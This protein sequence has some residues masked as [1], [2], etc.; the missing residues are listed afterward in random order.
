MYYRIEHHI[1][2]TLLNYS[3]ASKFLTKKL[4]EVYDLSGCKYFVI[5]NIRFN[6]AM[7]RSDLCD[8]NNLYIVAKGKSLSNAQIQIIN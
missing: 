1:I 7:L 5:N 4:I 6:T 2:P 8:H 3:P